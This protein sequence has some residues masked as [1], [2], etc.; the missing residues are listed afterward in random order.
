MS[1]YLV[2]LG[3]F[4]GPLDLLLRLIERQE[5]D[6]TLVSLALVA[7]QFLA[8]L[9]RLKEAT[10]ASLADFLVIAARLLVLK[11]RVL[12]PQVE[13]TEDE[14]QVDWEQ[15]L[16]ERLQ[17]Y[18]RYKQ[19]AE[20]LRALEQADRRTYPRVAPPP[21]LEQRYQPGELSAAEL[22][23]AY[24]RVL[25]AH[26]PMPPV[27]DVVPPMVVHMADC[28]QRIE[29]RVRRYARVRFSTIMKGARSRMEIIVT[30]MALLELLKL[31]RICALQEQPFGEIYIEAREPDP[32]AEIAPLDL[33]EYGEED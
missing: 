18:K 15:D 25:G 32:G 27:D 23:A 13:E 29:Q 31:Q 5:L 30:F 16:L 7:D 3:V 4:E 28:I 11:S 17:E 33:S 2:A 9:S 26:P 14:E 8:Y 21:K 10:A 6:I 19:A 1:S 20:H 12:L 24:Q 22:F